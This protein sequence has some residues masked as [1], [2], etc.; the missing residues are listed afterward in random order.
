MIKSTIK[1]RIFLIKI[2]IFLTLRIIAFKLVHMHTDG[3]RNSVPEDYVN[4]YDTRHFQ[5][6]KNVL[7]STH[8][9]WTK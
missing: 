5:C 2:R 3:L 9:R 7:S 6:L 1:T 4:K 8:T